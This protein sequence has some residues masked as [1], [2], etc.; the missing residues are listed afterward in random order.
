MRNF[1]AV[2]AD[3]TMT[4]FCSTQSVRY[5][6]ALIIGPGRFSFHLAGGAGRVA[7]VEVG[8]REIELLRR[9]ADGQHRARERAGGRC[10]SGRLGNFVL[11]RFDAVR[12][13]GAALRRGLA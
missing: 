13:T 7:C 6:H 11:H 3:G 10:W 5:S 8:E 4:V 9:T 12:E 1:K 2:S